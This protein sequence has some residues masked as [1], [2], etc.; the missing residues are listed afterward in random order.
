MMSRQRTLE[1]ERA[2]KA[3]DFIQDIKKLDK[4][5]REKYSA[6]ARK[7]PADI[8]SNGLGQTIAFWN[9]KGK[10]AKEKASAENK[11]HQHILTHVKDWLNDKN[12]MHLGKPNLVEWVSKEAQV[13]DY[14]RATAEAIAFLIWIK[15]FAEAELA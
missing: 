10:E 15:R 12:S 7:A 4:D 13:E 9:A 8:Q 2:S 14:R 11:A 5:V 3:W 6:L 1:Q